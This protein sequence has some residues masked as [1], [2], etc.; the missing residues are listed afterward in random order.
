MTGPYTVTTSKDHLELGQFI[1]LHYHYNMLND[2]ARMAGFKEALEYA[3]RPGARVLELG[4]GTGVLSFF[5]A[6]NAGKVWCVERNPELAAEAR[7]ILALNPDGEKIE[8]V[9]ADAYDYLPP[10]P[11]DAVI[12][13]MLHVG[14]LREKQVPVI[15][16]FKERYLEKFGPPL[17]RF[18][19]EATLQGVQPVQQSFDF[20]GFYAPTIL[21]QDPLCIQN[22][23]RELGDV[24]IYQMLS[25]AENIPQAIEWNG[26]MNIV[27]AGSLNA[28]RFITKN[29]LAILV[30]EQR[31]I[32]WRM[33]YLVLPLEKAISVRK[34]DSVPIR[35]SYAPGCPIGE[36]QDSLSVGG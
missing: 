8:I 26:V 12:C 4:G 35:F 33:Q 17:P 28:V 5:A 7:R 3:V 32:D 15:A 25:Y 23:T 36:L 13:E 2:G 19:P 24:A 31:T 1:P 20:H 9:E 6:K 16:S 10:E 22:K 30:E 34:G 14:L 27:G 11:V 18:V 29:V 21:F